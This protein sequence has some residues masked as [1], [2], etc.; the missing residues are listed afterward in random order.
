[1]V[2]KKKIAEL[3][4][5]YCIAGFHDAA[6]E[7][8]LVASEKDYPCHMFSLSGELEETLWEAPGG[9][10]SMVQV[11]GVQD[12]LLATRKFYSPNDSKAA[13][14]AAIYREGEGWK[15]H[16]LCTLPHVHRFDI[17]PVGDT[18][19]LFAATLLSRRDIKDDWSFPGKVYA[20]PL[21]RDPRAGKVALEVVQEDLLMN[22]GYTSR[23]IDGQAIPV[24]AS[25]NGIFAYTPA[26]Q[27]N[28]Q[29]CWE[30][31]KLLAD[32]ASEVRFMDLDGDGQEE[33]VTLS[34]FHGD[35]LRVY[36]ETEQGWA[37]A[38][39]Y[40]E[41]IPFAH[42]L[43]PLRRFGRLGAVVGHRKEAQRLLYLY[44]QDGIY[45]VDTLDTGAGSAN[46][47]AFIRDGKE[48]LISANREIN[49]VAMYWFEEEGKADAKI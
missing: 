34:P 47:L 22:H 33:M 16:I 17:I 28:G 40:E 30:S 15:E 18:L 37:L 49:E 5:C 32:P 13:Y 2:R 14:I 48:I 46:A 3:A 42:A 25:A 23:M 44:W 9:V 39:E 1:M 38:Y 26:R 24:I 8:I 11:P 20:G 6:G 43:C 7:H 41:K 19:Y 45:R 35:T 27:E 4:K 29:V 10:M 21:P 36:R 12:C 31:R